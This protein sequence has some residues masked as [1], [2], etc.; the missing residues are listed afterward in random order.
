M[1]VI[2]ELVSYKW[3]D[4][5]I[6][7][8]SKDSQSQVLLAF[9]QSFSK[10]QI[11]LRYAQVSG[12]YSPTDLRVG[13]HDDSFAQDTLEYS[14]G[15]Y[16]GIVESGAT[17][18]WQ[19]YPIGGELRPELQICIFTPNP[20]S[21]CSNT[22]LIPQ[23]FAN[24]ASTTHASWLWNYSAF[25]NPG[26]P[27]QDLPLAFQG[28]LQLGYQFFINNVSTVV[29]NNEVSIQIAIT[30][31][32]NAPFYYPLLLMAEYNN[33]NYTVSNSCE[34]LLPGNTEILATSFPYS[35]SAN[36]YL[37]FLNSYILLKPIIW[38]IV[39]A[40]INGVITIPLPS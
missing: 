37:L 4:E 24:C 34:N 22:G 33:K 30:N 38:A 25:Q 23:S 7:F 19:K 35:S 17:K 29:N 20:N 31:M 14:W 40:S 16:E 27:L 18:Q 32:G 9:N 13:F 12:N 10:T 8:A 11:L 21:S 5:Q 26:Y 15:F 2:I 36:S 6:P 28:A 39:G 1:M 3:H